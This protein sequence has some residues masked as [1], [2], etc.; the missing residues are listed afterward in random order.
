MDGIDMYE[1]VDDGH[2]VGYTESAA[3]LIFVTFSRAG[4]TPWD[5]AI[6]RRGYPWAAMFG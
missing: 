4:M 3:G 6:W 5:M 2:D 1:D